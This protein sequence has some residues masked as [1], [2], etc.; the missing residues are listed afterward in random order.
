MSAS[1]SKEWLAGH[2]PPDSAFKQTLTLVSDRAR[3]GEDLRFAVREFLDELF[4]FVSEV[5]GFRAL[6]LAQSPAAFR[7]RGIFIAEGALQ[8][9]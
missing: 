1:S 5:R 4:W 6:A 7:R 2:P 9:V 3:E 8:R